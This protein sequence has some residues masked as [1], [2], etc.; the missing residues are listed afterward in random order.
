MQGVGLYRG[1]S[2]RKQPRAIGQKTQVL[3]LVDKDF[4]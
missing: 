4:E 2:R 3:E 1:R